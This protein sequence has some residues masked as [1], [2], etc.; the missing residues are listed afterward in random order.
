MTFGRYRV[1]VTGHR[2]QVQVI[3]LLIS[4]WNKLSSISDF[5]SSWREFIMLWTFVLVLKLMFMDRITRQKY[6][7]ALEGTDVVA[8]MSLIKLI[9]MS[10]CSKVSKRHN[11][12]WVQWEADK[13]TSSVKNVEIVYSWLIA[14]N[15]P[16]AYAGNCNSTRP[17]IRDF[18]AVYEILI[19]CWP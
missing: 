15:S 8:V 19:G 13:F 6:E 14:T 2:S 12:H 18:M 11:F 17:T 3:I 4:N 16:H 7:S 9:V 1:R 10:S 5:D